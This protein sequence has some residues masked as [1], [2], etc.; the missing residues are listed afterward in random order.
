M[1]EMLYQR[2]DAFKVLGAARTHVLKPDLQAVAFAS[3][4]QDVTRKNGF[5]GHEGSLKP[6]RS[7]IVP[8][9][10]RAWNGPQQRQNRGEHF[11]FER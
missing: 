7:I 3:Q 5:D 2:L 9:A 10:L 8:S 1:L 4:A 6:E 11:R